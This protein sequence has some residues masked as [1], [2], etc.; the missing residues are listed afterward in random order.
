MIRDLLT[1]IFA[2]LLVSGCADRCGERAEWFVEPGQ[3][4]CLAGGEPSMVRVGPHEARVVC[5]C[6]GVDAG[7]EARR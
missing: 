1:A 6:P 2:A 5:V 4:R 7:S 3:T